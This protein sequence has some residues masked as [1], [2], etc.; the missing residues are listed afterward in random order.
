ME[1]AVVFDNGMFV[2]YKK[3]T[4]NQMKEK[5]TVLYSDV[6][7][8]DRTTVIGLKKTNQLIILV[9]NSQTRGKD[10]KETPSHVYRTLSPKP[11]MPAYQTSTE[12]LKLPTHSKC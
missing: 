7:V 10:D 5:E 11:A 2:G 9:Y 6:Q 12:I 3:T 8:P 1:A 4:K